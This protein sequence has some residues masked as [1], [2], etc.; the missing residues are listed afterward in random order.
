MKYLNSAI[1]LIFLVTGAFAQQKQ[2][3]VELLSQFRYETSLSDIWGYET[4]GNEYALVGL[5]NALSIVN[6]TDAENPKE[7]DRIPVKNSTWLDIKTWGHYAYVTTETGSGCL[8]VDLQHLPKYTNTYK[9]TGGNGGENFNSAKNVYIDEQGIMYVLG[10]NNGKGGCLM[11]DLNEDPTN[12]TFV[13]K[14]DDAYVHDAYANDNI[15][16]TSQGVEGKFAVVD[17]SDKSNPV[18]LGKAKT[19]GYTHNSWISN[20]KKTLFTTD[21]NSGAYIVS[22]DISDLKNIKELDR[23]C[24]SPGKGVIPHNTFV[25]GDYLISSYHTDG[26]TITDISD[27]SN[28]VQVGNYD[29]SPKS[30]ARKDGCWGVYPYLP[31]GNI[32]A[33]DGSEGM[34]VLKPNYKK[35]AHL[36]GLVLNATTKKP[37]ANATIWIDSKIINSDSNGL[38]EY[39]TADKDSYTVLVRKFGYDIDVIKNVKLNSGETTRITALLSPTSK[40]TKLSKFNEEIQDYLQL[41]PNPANDYVFVNGL[42]FSAGKVNYELYDVSGILVS[43]GVI[44]NNT[45]K[46]NLKQYEA[47]IYVAKFYAGNEILSINRIVKK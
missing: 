29:T 3:N 32:I 39:G 4:E 38:F 31:S 10:A 17:I 45:S 19:T 26:V 47:G 25:H 46:I 9:F 20:D 36:N 12:P 14:Y 37:I 6:I 21:E 1:I 15:L 27:P 28:M 16:Y 5:T 44:N 7:V 41:S 30:G 13:G 18:V 43:A 24:S 40:Q 33:S 22:W 11:Y 2:S 23:W 8:I 35:A 34:F 42:D